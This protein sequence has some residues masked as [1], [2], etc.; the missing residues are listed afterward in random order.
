MFVS[1]ASTTPIDRAGAQVDEAITLTLDFG[2]LAVGETAT[3]SFFTS[4]QINSG[5]TSTANDMLVGTNNVDNIFAGDGNDTIFDLAGADTISAG[6]GN[7]T[8][9]AGIGNNIF[10]GEAGVDTLDYRNSAAISADFISG[11]VNISGSGE[12]DK[13]TGIEAIVGSFGAD[14]ISGS[15]SVQTLTGSAG[16]D[17][18]TGAGGADIFAYVAPSD[19]EV[20]TT[21][22]SV[23][24]NG[25]D[26]I[27]DFVSGQDKISIDSAGFSLTSLSDGVNFEVISAGYDGTNATSSDFAA[28]APVLIYSQSD[29]ALIYDDNGTTAGYTVLLNNSVSGGNDIIAT[30]IVIG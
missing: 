4:F 23:G 27:A 11:V 28:S 14:V 24:S 29:A 30:D 3:Q 17:T 5:F 2:N 7:D 10:K 18:L 20:R 9:V 19:G 16:S 1:S 8:I 6:N 13:F 21:N 22:G 25:G 26:V 12:V 15:N